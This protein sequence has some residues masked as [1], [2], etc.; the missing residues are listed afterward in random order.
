MAYKMCQDCKYD[1]TKGYDVQSTIKTPMQ[2]DIAH[3]HMH[4]ENIVHMYMYMYTLKQHTF[5]DFCNHFSLR[6]EH[7][8]CVEQL[9]SITLWYTT[10]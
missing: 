10:C 7:C 5:L 3:I 4:T 2:H 1:P 6:I 9:V 8:T